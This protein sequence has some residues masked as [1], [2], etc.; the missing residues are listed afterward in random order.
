[1]RNE[2]FM[3]I[4]GY[5]GFYSIGDK[6]TVKSIRRKVQH[7]K[8]FKIVK[9]RTI[10]PWINRKGYAMVNLSKNG[11]ARTHYV[12][13]LNAD[14]NYPKIAGKPQVNHI[15]CNKS[16][17]EL[18]NLERVSSSEN[19]LHAYRNGLI[20]Q[21]TKIIDMCSNKTYPSIKEAS[22]DIG[23]SYTGCINMLLGKKPNTTCLKAA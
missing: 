15:D 2:T 23:Q 20:K 3:P 22:K 19:M 16:N 11:E 4:K 21:G 6:G 7:G 1:M 12:H 5:E 13:V 8:I 17:N 14:A 18:S 9:G 10:R